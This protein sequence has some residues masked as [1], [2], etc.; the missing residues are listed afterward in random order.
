M[1]LDAEGAAEQ[2]GV[3]TDEVVACDDRD[4]HDKSLR[5]PATELLVEIFGAYRLLATGGR[6]HIGAW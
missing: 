5:R 6:T 1:P 2:G 3:V 4:P